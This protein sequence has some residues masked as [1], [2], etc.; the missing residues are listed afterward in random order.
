[1]SA[2]SSI[3]VI[4]A[5][6]A[7]IQCDEDV[8]LAA[9]ADADDLHKNMQFSPYIG[10]LSVKAKVPDAWAVQPD[11]KMQFIP[12][13]DDLSHAKMTFRSYLIVYAQIDEYSMASKEIA[14]RSKRLSTSSTNS[15]QQDSI[16]RFY[17]NRMLV[18][19]VCEEYMHLI[20]RHKSCINEFADSK[21]WVLLF[22]MFM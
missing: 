14:E 16:E 10:D 1:M 18:M 17:E 6:F 22:E 21:A 2:S 9:Q 11:G 15:H 5:L 3:D 12:F 7:N 20:Q 13:R 19:R 8:I 4:V